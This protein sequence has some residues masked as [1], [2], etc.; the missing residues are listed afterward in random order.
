MVDGGRTED[1]GYREVP[2][3]RQ[4]YLSAETST[5]G[6][7]YGVAQTDWHRVAGSGVRARAQLVLEKDINRNWFGEGA[8]AQAALPAA[9]FDA[10]QAAL[11]AARPAGPD[12]TASRYH[13]FILVR[14][15][16]RLQAE[17]PLAGGLKVMA[18]LGGQ[19]ATLHLY[20]GRRVETEDGP[21]TQGPTKVGV[22]RPFGAGGGRE[23]WGRTGVAYDTRD[24][25]PDPRR[26]WFC[27]LVVDG[28]DRALLSDFS[29]ARLTAAV[30]RFQPVAGGLVLAGRATWSQVTGQPP[31]YE[32]A[33]LGYF[34]GPVDAV[35]GGWTLRGYKENRF[36]GR[37][38]ALANLE[39]RWKVLEGRKA[40]LIV[41]GFADGGRA[42][43]RAGDATLRD[44]KGAAGGG[45]R[46]TFNQVMVLNM[47]YGAS[48]ED[49]NTFI[50]FGHMF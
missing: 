31:F 40:G 42:F 30:R 23:L 13:K 5:L 36:A 28:R 37:A 14:P 10:Y 34:E 45:V 27:D 4:F 16:L 8:A 11:D 2:Y 49:S 6:R 15:A 33:T 41:L 21:R 26:G 7:Q 46:V 44:W 50:S 22:E 35:G 17:R 47:S 19:R 1:P 38:V 9:D 48:G 39:A 24:F 25:E 43:A 29:Y 18:A 20:D 12:S 3:R 32:L